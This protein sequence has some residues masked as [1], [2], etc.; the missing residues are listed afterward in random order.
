MP[1]T[2]VLTQPQ[3]YFLMEKDVHVAVAPMK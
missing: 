3:H 1:T 2:M